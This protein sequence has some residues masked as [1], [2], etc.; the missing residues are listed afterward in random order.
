M[1]TTTAT[2]DE[3]LHLLTLRREADA[4]VTESGGASPGGSMYGGMLAAQLLMVGAALTEL[5]LPQSLQLLFLRPGDASAPMKYRAQVLRDGR[6]IA[7]FRITGAQDAGP[8]VDGTVSFTLSRTGIEHQIPRMPAAPDPET[9]VPHWRLMNGYTEPPPATH[10]PLERRGPEPLPSQANGD[11]PVFQWWCRPIAVLP[12][13][14][15]IHAAALVHVSDFMAGPLA[16]YYDRLGKQASLDHSV[17]FHGEPR[18]EG[19]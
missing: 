13:D 17:W 12:D 16:K 3:F 19:W 7:T 6:S 8:V 11:A 10:H 15:R 2:I 1:T 14:P 9:L 5:P 18:C 4:F